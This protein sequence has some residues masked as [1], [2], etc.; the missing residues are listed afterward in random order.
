MKLLIPVKVQEK[1]RFTIKKEIDFINLNE[2]QK[3]NLN[4]ILI[5]LWFYIYNEQIKD[6]S[7]V[8]LNGF[9]NIYYKNLEKFRIKINQKSYHY[10]H[11]LNLLEEVDLIKS[12]DKYSTKTFSKSY[13]I[14]TSIIEDQYEEV[15]LDFDKIFTNIHNKSYW[16]RKYPN[17]KK[18][19]KDTYEVKIELND[20]IVWM[21]NNI[22][23]ELKPVIKNGVLERRYLTTERMYNYIIESLKINYDN[24][25]FKIS[26]EGRF[27][28]S[29][30]NLS[31]TALPFIRLKRRK[32]KE[33]DVANCQP[34]ILSNIIKNDKYKKDCELG[35]FYD[36]LSKKLNIE[37][38]E[39]KMLS[40][41]Y[42]FFSNKQLKSGKIY[43]AMKE[44]YGD[45][46]EQI[47]D[48][49]KD[50]EISKEMQKIESSI[51]VD[52][53]ANLDFIMML[54]HD[55]VYVYE[56]D[57]DLIKMYIIKEFKNIGL[58]PTIK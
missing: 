4:K 55:A 39:C 30:T 54:R 20:Y 10:K 47:N 3:S 42:I 16:L 53:I 21:K 15:E 26:N 46:I 45:V 27:Y 25:W 57:Y 8:N 18:Q 13:R 12:N 28:N 35:I 38:N 1:I 41:K 36:N 56:E 51:F 11:L 24:I 19:I 7:I 22:G 37:R 40:Y 6:D 58:N 5:S 9:T 17:H 52:K 29:T 23:I 44:L 14:N 32:V 43:D 31:Y 48:I 2:K 49:R 33:L 34:L 50:K